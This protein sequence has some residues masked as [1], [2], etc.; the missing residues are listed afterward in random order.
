[1]PVTII[2]PWVQPAKEQDVDNNG[3]NPNAELT[4]LRYCDYTVFEHG[5]IGPHTSGDGLDHRLSVV[6]PIRKLLAHLGFTG[7]SH[8]SG[9]LIGKLQ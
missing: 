6:Q 3:N 2:A 7:L 8:C 4:L 9:T 1:M 5:A